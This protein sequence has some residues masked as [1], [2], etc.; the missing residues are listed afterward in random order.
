[1]NNDTLTIRPSTEADLAAVTAIY[2]ENVTGGSG[3]FE[4]EAPDEAEM[5]R[6]RAEVL[7]RKLPWLVAEAG[8]R[9][10][11][12]AYANYFRP[13][14]AY[15][16]YLEDSI[17]LAAD[18]RGRGIGRLLLAELVARCE[19]AGARQMLAV[20]GDS[21]NKGSIGVHRALGFEDCG[22]LKSAGWKFGRWIDV[23]LMQRAL[24]RGD[25]SAPLE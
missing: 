20:I 19:A 5:A 3:T 16:Y 23:V 9:V 12:Y 6:R 13:R 21:A 25:T 10:L 14:L 1:M 2:A 17:Y 18:A 7:A 24:G 22:I 4:T 11:G 8:G 15:R